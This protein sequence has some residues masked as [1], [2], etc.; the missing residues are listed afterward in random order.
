M[1]VHTTKVD[2]LIGLGKFQEAVSACQAAEKAGVPLQFER[3][4][5]LYKLGK[6][7]EA[8]EAAGAAEDQ[9]PTGAPSRLVAQSLYRSGQFKEAA[10]RYAAIVKGSEEQERLIEINAAA[11]LVCAGKGADTASLPAVADEEQ[12]KRWDAAY[13]GACAVADRDPRAAARLAHSAATLRASALAAK[14]SAPKAV[15]GSLA[16]PR[17]LRG[18]LLARARHA[19]A[20]RD[21]LKKVE[22]S[23][24][25]DASLPGLASLA[26]ARAAHFGAVLPSRAAAAGVRQAR[27]LASSKLQ[28]RLTPGQQQ[29]ARLAGAAAAVRCGLLAEA[30]QLLGVTSGPE[31]GKASSSSAS[32][33]SSSKGSDVGEALALELEGAAMPWLVRATAAADDKRRS[34]GRKASQREGAEEAAAA[35]AARTLGRAL[36]TKGG[37]RGATGGGSGVGFAGM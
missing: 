36:E 28:G 35:E 1:D 9:S 32:S 20:A 4:Y 5:S 26:R 11:S 10:D 24:P 22:A 34:A 13:A 3:G 12:A 31:G 33:S 7:N 2:V 14:G 16:L 17:L 30:K 27:L 8:I 15:E 29:A 37:K 23:R 21:M 18:V 19:E 25:V 6:S